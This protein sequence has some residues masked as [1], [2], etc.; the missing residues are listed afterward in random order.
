MRRARAGMAWPKPFRVSRLRLLSVGT[1]LGG[2]CLGFLLESRGWIRWPE[3]SV[4]WEDRLDDGVYRPATMR[5]E[6]EEIALIYIGASS[7]GWSNQPELAATIKE[8]KVLLASRAQ[9]TGL[10]FAAVG[11]ATDVVADAGI[12]HLDKFGAFDEVISGRGWSNAGVQEY[13]FETIPGPAA[14]PQVLVVRRIIDSDGDSPT[15]LDEQLLTRKLGL[16]RIA[17]WVSQGAPLP[18]IGDET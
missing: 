8:L 17:D 12:E 13:V 4:Q 11:I 9:D 7:C 5:D 6:D 18:L 14:T 15:V 1:V 16:R 2:V 10:G 3:V